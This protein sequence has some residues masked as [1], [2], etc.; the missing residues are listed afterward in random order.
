[1]AGQPRNI[2]FDDDIYSALMQCVAKR[3]SKGDDIDFTKLVN[4]SLRMLMPIH[5]W[6]DLSD[7]VSGLEQEVIAIKK[8]Q[9]PNQKEKNN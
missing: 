9:S 7:R 2:R 3:R 4:E 8:W 6:D 1:M 5:T